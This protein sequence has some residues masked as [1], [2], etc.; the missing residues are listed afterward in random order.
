M[1][2]IRL[3]II[4][5]LSG[6]CVMMLELC[7]SR[8]LAPMIGSSIFVW[9]SLIGAI[10]AALS[11]GYWKGGVI[12]DR[13]PSYANLSI[14]F[15]IASCFVALI[16]IMSGPLLIAVSR[17]AWD[18]RFQAL[19]SAILLFA[20]PS[21]AMGMV[22]PYAL[23]LSVTSVDSSGR[24]VGLLTAC[25]TLGSLAGTFLL[26]FFLLSKVGTMNTLFGISGILAICAILAAPRFRLPLKLALF[27]ALGGIHQF[28]LVFIENVAALG[29]HD[30]DTDYQRVM[31]LD[32]TTGEPPKHLRALSTGPEGTQSLMDKDHPNDFVVEYLQMFELGLKMSPQKSRLLLIGGGGFSFPKFIASKYPDSQLDVVEL[33][34]GITGIARKYFEFIDSPKISIFHEDARI[35]LNRLG[36]RPNAEKYDVI[37]AD[38]YS[39][40]ANIPFHLTTR[41]FFAELSASIKEDGVAVVNVISSVEGPLSCMYRIMERELL[42]HFPETYILRANPG[43]TSNQRQNVVIIARRG[44]ARSFVPADYPEIGGRLA[45]SLWSQP[46]PEPP[47]LLN[48]D[49]APSEYVM[50]FGC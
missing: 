11:L 48:D 8:V 6:A 33:D 39:S 45:T 32:Y 13:N 41:E 37:F 43:A 50:N 26:G 49:F 27:V 14:I 23:R 4:V 18:P 21:V 25:S 3:A 19:F 36:E 30:L 15:V 22:P 46:R 29:I 31:I 9:T 42:N 44:A 35:F 34:P 5:F 16:P 20:A 1:I 10:L 38:A 40:A 7:G 24:S 2:Q 47:F 12:A 17:S 28:F